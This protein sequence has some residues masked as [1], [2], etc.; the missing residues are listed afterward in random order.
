MTTLYN[1]GKPIDDFRLSDGSSFSLEDNACKDVEDSH[2]LEILKEYPNH[3]IKIISVVHST[4]VSTP[5]VSRETKEVFVNEEEPEDR[6]FKE[7]T[8][9]DVFACSVCG[10]TFPTNKGMRGHMARSHEA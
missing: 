2:A 4:E 1:E 6:F 5:V 3:G 7:Q 10:T 8:K 9:G